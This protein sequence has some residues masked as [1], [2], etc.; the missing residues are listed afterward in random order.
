MTWVPLDIS[1]PGDV[2]WADV[3]TCRLW[4]LLLCQAQASPVPGVVRFSY[5]VVARQVAM[6]DRRRHRAPS[7]KTLRRALRGLEII[8]RVEVDERVQG[9]EKARDRGGAQGYLTVRLK[10][11]PPCGVGA[12][13]SGTGSE[14]AQGTGSDGDRDA[15]GYTKRREREFRI[16]NPTD[17]LSES[18]ADSDELGRF[19]DLWNREVEGF[20]VRAFRRRKR[21]R[22][23]PKRIRDFLRDCDGD[24]NLVQACVRVFVQ[25]DFHQDRDV[26]NRFGVDTFLRPGHRSDYVD[27][28]RDLLEGGAAVDRTDTPERRARAA[29]DLGCAPGD[30]HF[31]PHSGEYCKDASTPEDES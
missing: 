8:G 30:L 2:V 10:N 29:G 21:D 5:P 23:S 31:D 16:G 13:A 15:K 3:W 17:S 7:R 9:W 22:T 20:N 19:R 6:M 4:I 26:A 18:R 12:S 14:A 24:W 28:G 11:W 25:R 27:R 1:L